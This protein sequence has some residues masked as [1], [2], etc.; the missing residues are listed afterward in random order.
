MTVSVL[1][2][3]MR[4]LQAWQALYESDNLDSITGPD[5]ATYHLV[6]IEYLY[7]RRVLLSPRQRQAIELCLYENVK[8]KDATL[9]MGVSPTNPVAMYATNGLARLCNL[10]AAGELSRFRPEHDEVVA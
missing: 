1:R 10:I 4:H 2:E 8:E 6:D 5:G 3:L 7:G 9:V